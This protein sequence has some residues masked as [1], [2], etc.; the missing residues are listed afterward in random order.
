MSFTIGGFHWTKEYLPRPP[1]TQAESQSGLLCCPISA[2]TT[3]QRSARQRQAPGAQ[4]AQATFT[5]WIERSL[6]MQRC[7]RQPVAAPQRAARAHS[8]RS[9]RRPAQAPRHVVRSANGATQADLR[10]VSGPSRPAGS[11]Q[12]RG[13]AAQQARGG[14]VSAR[15]GPPAA[16]L[17]RCWGTPHRHPPLPALSSLTSPNDGRH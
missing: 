9:A 5:V 17:E 10:H 8:C 2:T 13:G 3:A 14:A 16:R 7:L 11:C 6:P 1:A 12:G 4:A 15:A